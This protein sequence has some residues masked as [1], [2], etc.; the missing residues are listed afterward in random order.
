MAFAFVICAYLAYLVFDVKSNVEDARSHGT[1]AK[2]AI[3]DGDAALAQSEARSAA[4]AADAARDSSNDPVWKAFAA[5]PGLGSP[6]TS[7]KQMTSSVSDLA[8]QVLVPSAALAE[9]ISPSKL[10]GP[11]NTLA[12]QPLEVA[13]PKL[14]EIATKAERINQGAQQISDS[15]P[16]QVSDARKQLTSQIAETARFLRGTE[17]AALIAPSMLGFDGPRHYFVAMQTPSQARATGGLVGG[18]AVMSAEKGHVTTPQLGQN[19]DMSEPTTPQLDLGPDY[20]RLYAWTR[21]YLDVRNSNYSPNFPDAARIWIANW[22]GQTGQQLDGALALDPIALSYVLKVTG[23]VTLA[24]GEKITADNVVPITLSTSYLRFADDNDARKHYLQEISKAVIG[25]ISTESGNTGALLE[26]LGRGVHERRIMV[27]SDHK[28]EQQVLE[29]TA[30]GHQIS[31]TSA[32]YMNVTMTNIS[33]NK[34]DYYLKREIAYASGVCSGATREST[35]TVR[36][37]N[38]LH[39]TTLP[40]YVIGTRM[41]RQTRFPQ[42]TNYTSAQFTLTRGATVQHV[43]IDGK[44]TPFTVGTLLGHPVVFAQVPIPP[45]MSA[46][47]KVVFSEPTSAHGEAL[48]PV[49]PLV[50]NPVPRV[51]VPVCGPRS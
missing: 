10:R 22:R 46:E 2:A 28:N 18:F 29:A 26:A 8:S 9:T 36:L 32:P 4:V 42:G 43:I 5:I 35:A 39:D 23:P 51:D 12:L 25:Q 11:D 34:T 24:D 14:A 27:Y 40:D 45:G 48:V 15:W 44:E 21:S 41:K 33:A 7:V 30:L 37:T 17:T 1:S 47:V 20:N 16:S 38:T 3:L 6:F 49:Q 19:L 50:D 13:Q 31:N